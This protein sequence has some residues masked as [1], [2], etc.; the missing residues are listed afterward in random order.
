MADIVFPYNLPSRL[1]LIRLIQETHPRFN[2]KDEY[3][4]FD[5]PYFAPTESIPGRTFIEV[6]QTDLNV[7]RQ[8]VYRR[9]D[10][11]ITFK[12]GITIRLEAPVTPRKIVEEINRTRGM[13]LGA[14][15]VEISDREIGN[16]GVP[17]NYM[18]QAKPKSLVWFGS[19]PVYVEPMDRPQD[20]RILEDGSSRLVESGGYRM[21]EVV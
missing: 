12:G 20:I 13:K 5:E 10:L 9:L 19:V 4:Q 8:Y 1:A 11:D 7:K 16:P 15:D 21:L 3:T 6:E 14:D 2:L 17:V 18:L